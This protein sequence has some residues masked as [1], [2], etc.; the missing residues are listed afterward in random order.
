MYS[1]EY[2]IFCIK[3][4]KD[5]SHFKTIELDKYTK[6]SIHD[7]ATSKTTFRKEVVGK[8]G[9]IAYPEG[10]IPTQEEVDSYGQAAIYYLPTIPAIRESLLAFNAI[11]SKLLVEKYTSEDANLIAR[12]VVIDYPTRIQAMGENINDK[13][14]EKT[15][16]EQAI[17]IVS[18]VDQ[19]KKKQITT[20]K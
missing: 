19:W 7:R 11:K 14:V 15:I 4:D 13:P 18:I 10:K 16:E 1:I 12:L 20:K 8:T 3:A 2:F 9:Y 6:D 17:S 5:I